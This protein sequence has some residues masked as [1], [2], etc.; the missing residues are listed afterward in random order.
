MEPLFVCGNMKKS[1]KNHFC[2]NSHEEKRINNVWK[3]DLLLTMHFFFIRTQFLADFWWIRKKKVFELCLP[4]YLATHGIVTLFFHFR[5]IAVRESQSRSFNQIFLWPLDR[6]NFISFCKF[7]E[8]CVTFLFIFTVNFFTW[9]VLIFFCFFPQ[10]MEIH[11]INPVF[12]L[13]ISLE[14][15]F[16]VEERL[17]LCE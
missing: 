6:L 1:H 12:F 17:K 8:I 5:S 10:S 13:S 3:I 16:V 2:M 9:N 14:S 15:H 4:E 7:L 11:E